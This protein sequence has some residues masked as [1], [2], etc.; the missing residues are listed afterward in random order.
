MIGI[1]WGT[2]NFRAFRM[3]GGVVTD[4]VAS[5]PGLL[6]ISAGGFGAALTASVGTWLRDGETR[7][8]MAGMVGSRQG[9]VEAAYLPCP[10]DPAALAAAALAV[11]F[12]G[13][14]VRLVPGLSADGPDG[15][16]EVM[17][18]EEMQLVGVLDRIGPD[19]MVCLPGTHSKWVHVA[20][21][22]IERFRTHLTGEAFAALRG[23]TILGRLMDQGPAGPG[24]AFLRGVARS[25]ETGGLLHHL[26]GIRTLGLFG[27]L[28]EADAASY[29]SGLLIGHEVR[30][31]DLRA[32]VSLVGAQGLCALY[33]AA[34][35]QCG[36]RAEIIGQDAA[37]LGLARI[38]EHVAW[39]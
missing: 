8:L 19:A 10:A 37:A 30:S 21:G 22:R 35:A 32:P 18:G 2:T 14:T 39:T 20:G 16:P 17:R 12:E 6:S 38:A 26:F 25:G 34:I 1:D 23:H 31:A 24:D 4:R 33:A 3:D 9:W 29:L 36:G 15:V 13:A 5:G 7:V 27:R 11:P 28:A